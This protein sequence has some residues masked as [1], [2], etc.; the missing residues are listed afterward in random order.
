LYRSKELLE[1]NLC[2]KIYLPVM[3]FEPT[4]RGTRF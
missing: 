1:M 4:G 3:T 2:L